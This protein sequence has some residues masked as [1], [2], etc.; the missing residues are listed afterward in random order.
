[1]TSGWFSFDSNLDAQSTRDVPFLSEHKKSHDLLG[2]F[3]PTAHYVH[4]DHRVRLT[5]TLPRRGG[6]AAAR[7]TNSRKIDPSSASSDGEDSSDVYSDVDS[8]EAPVRRSKR[9]VVT[10]G[11]RG[12][13]L[14][15]SPRKTRSRV[16]TLLKSS[17]SDSDVGEVDVSI[18]RSARGRRGRRVV[19]EAADEDF[20]MGSSDDD[21]EGSDLPK[22]KTPRKI[23]APRPEYG[24]VRQ[25]ELTRPEEGVDSLHAHR[26]ICE[27]CHEPSASTLLL[28]LRKRGKKRAHK[29]HTD[30]DSED[31][32]ESYKKLGGWVRW[33][34]Q[35]AFNPHTD[36][37]D[38]LLQYAMLCRCT[39]EVSCRCPT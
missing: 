19:K 23:A 32:E 5:V 35:S 6:G 22:K 20:E 37:F 38:I 10:E 25:L 12:R 30:E 18:R 27:R 8:N 13:D 7:R 36:G 9:K 17:P 16:K 29:R 15:F 4:P 34:V 2:A 33:Y 26:S 28:K 39:L 14:P 31:E 3:D 1:V 11:H 21:D 24:K